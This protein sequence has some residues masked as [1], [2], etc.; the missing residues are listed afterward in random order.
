MSM[1]RETGVASSFP[2][3]INY[4]GERVP[5]KEGD[6]WGG[7]G[8]RKLGR[9]GREEGVGAI[10]GY[11]SGRKSLLESYCYGLAAGALAALAKNRV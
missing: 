2:R 11:V 1:K 5:K 6:T 4:I 8:W 3:H 10:G 9:K 7:E